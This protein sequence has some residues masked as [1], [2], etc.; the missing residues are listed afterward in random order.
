MNNDNR[1]NPRLEEGLVIYLQINKGCNA[2]YEVFHR[3]QHVKD[4]NQIFELY[5]N[6]NIGIYNLIMNLLN[7]NFLRI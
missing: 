3:Q 1:E 6:C 7:T 2:K 4:G 5:E